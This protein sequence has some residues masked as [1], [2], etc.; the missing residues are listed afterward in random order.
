MRT[1][2]DKLSNLVCKAK[3][4]LEIWLYYNNVTT[5]DDF[6]SI[7]PN[8][9]IAYY[10]CKRQIAYMNKIISKIEQLKGK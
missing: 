5:I 10:E 9:S 6:F 4:D 8:D 2:V 1:I 7:K 3:E